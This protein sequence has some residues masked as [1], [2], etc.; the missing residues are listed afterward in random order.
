[1]QQLHHASCKVG[2]DVDIPES[3]SRRSCFITVEVARSHKL[4]VQPRSTP[5]SSL[6]KLVVIS[7]LVASLTVPCFS[8]S[9]STIVTRDA[10]VK[11]GVTPCKPV[12]HHMWPTCVRIQ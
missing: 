5:A 12:W 8:S 10:M 9:S 11:L 2:Q 4:S 3:G 1:M 6:M 7:H